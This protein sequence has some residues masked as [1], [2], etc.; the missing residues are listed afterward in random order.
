[1]PR[2]S[3]AGDRPM[4]SIGIPTYN[5]P[6]GL[7]KLLNTV[8]D[9]TYR[10]LEIIISDNCSTD[11]EVQST[12]L[13]FAELDDR[14]VHFRQSKNIGLEEN[15]NFVY[16]KAS[17]R[18]FVWMGDDDYF[19]ANY[20]EACV[21]HLQKN[22]EI[23]L[24]SGIA[25]YYSKGKHL[26]DEKMSPLLQ[27]KRLLRIFKYYLTVNKNG[28]FYG[29]FRNHQFQRRPLGIHVG[30]DLSFMGKLAILGKID[31]I[32]TT[33]Y[34]RSLD[35]SSATKKKMIERFG[36]NWMERTFFE[37]YVCAEIARHI[38]REPRARKKFG[39]ISRKLIAVMVF[40]E[41]NYIMVKGFLKKMFGKTN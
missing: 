18:Y 10:N 27:Q 16:T 11:P 41:L 29:V 14:I 32:P 36:L 30:C 34:H 5:R 25:K 26:F 19:D 17:G 6:A 24:C 23:I 35:G 21:T 9:Q 2:P 12:I 37:F 28:K 1:M 40:L 33:S 20:I 4:V 8:K 7:R 38:F 15:F 22:P 39:P 3:S 13:L 31:A